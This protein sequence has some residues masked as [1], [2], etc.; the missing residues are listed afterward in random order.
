MI[1]VCTY[2]NNFTRRPSDNKDGMFSIDIKAN[3]IVIR[4]RLK[5][6]HLTMNDDYL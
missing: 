6:K 5:N 2:Y 4:N 1:K 3:Y